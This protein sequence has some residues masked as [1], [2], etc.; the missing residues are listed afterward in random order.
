MQLQLLD[1]NISFKCKINQIIDFLKAYIS[2]QPNTI[3]CL[4]EVLPHYYEALKDAFGEENIAYSLHHRSP[5]KFEGKNR[6]L[7]VA[8][9]LNKG[10]IVNSHLISSAIVP[11]RCLYTSIQLEK[12]PIG[13]LNFHSLTG[14][15]Y[16]NAKAS[17]FASIATYIHENEAKIDFMCFDANE[18]LKDYQDFDKVEFYDNGDKGKNAGLIL[19]KDK[20]HDLTDALRSYYSQESIVNDNEPLIRSHKGKRFDYIFHAT[21]WKVFKIDYLMEASLEA[22]SDHSMV[23]ALFEANSIA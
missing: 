5:G 22:T 14:K 19:G 10:R 17:N 3:I 4:Q 2:E 12:T 1:W 8:T 11:E 6:A 23:R 9:I 20:V 7:G 13:I 21:K 16:K 18:P 15:S